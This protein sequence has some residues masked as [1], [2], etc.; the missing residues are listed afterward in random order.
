[1]ETEFKSGMIVSW[2]DPVTN[3]LK[4]GQLVEKHQV[5]AE[6]NAELEDGDEVTNEYV[7]TEDFRNVDYWDWEIKGADGKTYS[8]QE[9]ELCMLDVED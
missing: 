3:Q 1:M 2:R 6:A 7:P 4:L 5:V 8:F 9:S